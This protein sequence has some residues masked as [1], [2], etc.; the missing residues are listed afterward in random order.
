LGFPFDCKIR[1]EDWVLVAGAKREESEEEALPVKSFGKDNMPSFSHKVKRE[2][3]RE[4][5]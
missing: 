3:L 2:K 4:Y 5:A 1:F